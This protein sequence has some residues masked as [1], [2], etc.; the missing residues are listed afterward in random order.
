MRAA[1]MWTTAALA[2]ALCIVST[3]GAQAARRIPS[4]IT[5]AVQDSG[6][7]Q[8]DTKR[9]ALRKPA[10]TLA[11]AGVKP[12]EK[13]A[14]LI[15]AAGYYTRLL[16]KIV[17]PSGH[18]YM[19][20]PPAPKNPRPG[21]PSMTDM[22]NAIA[23]NP[24]YSNVSVVSLAQPGPGLGLPEPVDLVWTTEN[25][26]DLHNGPSADIAAFDKRVFDAL[27]PG[28][29]FFIEDHAAASDADPSVTHTLHRINP[30][31]VKKELKAAG[32][33][34]LGQSTILRNPE[35][36]HTKIVFD[37]SIRSHTDRFMFKFKKPE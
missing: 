28:G 3:G 21:R 23:Q 37:P 31:Q 26:H 18:V 13:V 27:K 12:G 1:S 4:Y 35:D 36:P 22:A 20:T 24:E 6:R 10:A 7:P 32:F 14:E 30:N 8:S 5:A 34:Y 19:M 33:E 2:A 25:Y 16:S 29:I 17:G 15:P 9:D 11:F